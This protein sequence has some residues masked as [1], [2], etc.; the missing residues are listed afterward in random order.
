[1]LFR[2]LV[3]LL[4]RPG[5]LLL[6][7]VAL[8]IIFLIYGIPIFATSGH[9]PKKMSTYEV[10]SLCVGALTLVVYAFTLFVIAHQVRLDHERRRKQATIDHIEKVKT[11]YRSHDDFLDKTHGSQVIL[12]NLLSKPD[13]VR[14]IRDMLSVV[15]H[16]STGALIG[17]FDIDLLDRLS[18]SFFMRL[19]KRVFPFI[20]HTRREKNNDQIYADFSTLIDCIERNRRLGKYAKRTSR[21]TNEQGKIT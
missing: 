7:A 1:M 9:D 16:M 20:E 4:L 15:E 3:S 14:Q 19:H 17:V 13:E 8:S 11:V 21:R 6:L 18:G 2:K 12:V 5:V 10:L